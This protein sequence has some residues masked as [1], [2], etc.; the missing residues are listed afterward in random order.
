[1]RLPW[2]IMVLALW[3]GFAA[4]AEPV[5]P[6]VVQGHHLTPQLAEKYALTEA[7]HQVSN[8]LQQLEPP[9]LEWKPTEEYV[10]EKLLKGRGAPGPDMSIDAAQPAKTWIIKLKPPDL[11]EF[12]RLNQEALELRWQ[13]E[14]TIQA[15]DRLTVAGWGFLAVT[16]LLAAAASYVWVLARK[17]KPRNTRNTRKKGPKGPGPPSRHSLTC[18]LLFLLFFVCFVC[19]V[20]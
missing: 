5:W 4:G 17:S 10:K 2:I 16:T 13:K 7:V 3:P 11:T 1:M 14:R 19:F 15:Q 18:F 8:Y 9:L 12:R 6:E 20:V